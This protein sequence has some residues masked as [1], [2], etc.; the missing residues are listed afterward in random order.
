MVIFAQAVYWAPAVKELE[1]VMEIVEVDCVL[2]GRV[3][4]EVPTAVPEQAAPLYN[5]KAVLET[6]LSFELALA[7]TFVVVAVMAAVC[8]TPEAPFTG[9]QLVTAGLVAAIAGAAHRTDPKN[10]NNASRLLTFF[11]CSPPAQ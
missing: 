11:I 7:L 1:G 2:V 9:T 3:G 6:V 4:F 8:E 10:T 5:I